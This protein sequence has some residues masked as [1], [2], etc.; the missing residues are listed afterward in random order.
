MGAYIE[1][2]LERIIDASILGIQRALMAIEVAKDGDEPGV[3]PGGTADGYT[4]L[5]GMSVD[6]KI[7]ESA[8][9]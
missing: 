1:D 8:C 9:A 3:R 7:A 6:C 5:S 4:I 2:M